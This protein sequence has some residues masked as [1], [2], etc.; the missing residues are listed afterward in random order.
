M[1]ETPDS[2]RTYVIGDDVIAQTTDNG[3]TTTDYLLYDGHG[4]VRQ[5]VDSTG[6][7]IDSYSYDGYGVMLGGNPTPASPAATPLLY[8]SEWL[9][10]RG[11]LV[12]PQ[13][14]RGYLIMN[15]AKRR[16]PSEVRNVACNM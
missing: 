4:S 8:A 16:R 1:T 9:M 11:Y 2:I 6:T 14:G 10:N 13:G 15:S 12:G 3:T 7:V 5:L